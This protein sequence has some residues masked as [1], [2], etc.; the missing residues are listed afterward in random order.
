MAIGQLLHVTNSILID[1][2]QLQMGMF[3]QLEV[4]WMNHPFPV[5]SFKITSAQQIRVLQG[6]GSKTIRYL[7]GKSTLGSAGGQSQ[8]GESMSVVPVPAVAGGGAALPLT[9]PVLTERQQC[10]ERCDTRFRHAVQ[11]FEQ[12][13]VL[14][15]GQPLQARG[16][17]E[18]MV[19]H[20]L[21]EL[22]GA[23]D[24]VIHLLS[25]NASRSH[26]AHAV[27][28]MVL[29]LLLGKSMGMEPDAL[30]DLG[31]AALLHDLGKQVLGVQALGVQ[32]LGGLGLSTPSSTVSPETWA[33]YQRH[34][35]ESVE[36]AQRMGLLAGVTTPI[37]QHHEW[38]DG[39]GF[40]LRLLQE[41][42]ALAGQILAL[43]NA[44]DRL[45]NT[46]D[47]R[48]QQT[49]HEALSQLFSRFQGKFSAPVLSSFIRMLGV[50]PPGSV[51]E[52]TDGRYA[53]VMAVNG[54]RPLKPVVLPYSE[55]QGGQEGLL[56]SLAEHPQ[57]GIR[58]GINPAQLPRQALDYLSPRQ[59]VCYYFERA[60]ALE[61]PRT[62]T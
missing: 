2:G 8:A 40:P 5:N 33:L 56:L 47:M 12:I 16:H 13:V 58:R 49:P 26:S 37:A 27:N 20:C 28:V 52:L 45:C 6:L 36:I 11:G 10:L 46:E 55:E 17:G 34:V 44:Y 15:E 42:M 25:E 43:V 19:G 3:V 4:G 60:V 23:H 7:P 14:L 35:G 50:F 38:A 21:Q 1:V 31:L 61:P 39:T 32:A 9:P 18:S 59:R 22:Q 62:Q 48:L 24:V 41:D 30:H 51:V 29:S 57:L 53:M 54:S